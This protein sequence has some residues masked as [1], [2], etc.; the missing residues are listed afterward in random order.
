MYTTEIQKNIFQEENP[1]LRKEKIIAL[2]KQKKRQ[3]S[4]Y[5]C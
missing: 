1:K 2:L 3:N 4:K 5:S